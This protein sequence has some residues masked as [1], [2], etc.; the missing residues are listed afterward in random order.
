[1]LK[2]IEEKDL[3]GKGVVG[4]PDA[5]NLTARQ[6]QYKFEEIV[7]D[8]VIPTVNENSAKTATIEDINNLVLKGGSGDMYAAFYD[9]DGDGRVNSADDGIHG[10]EFVYDGETVFLNGHGENGKFK[11]G[12]DITADGIFVNGERYAV[13]CGGESEI[14]LSD[15]AVYMFCLD[16]GGKT[17]NFN[18][19]GRQT[20][21]KIVCSVTEPQ[22][23][24]PNTVWVQTDIL[25]TRYRICRQKPESTP[26]GL[27]WLKT[28]ENGVK[29][30]ILKKNTVLVNIAGAVLFSQGDEI[31]CS[32]SVF[33]GTEWQSTIA[34]LYENGTFSDGYDAEITKSEGG[35]NTLTKKS[36]CFTLYTKAYSGANFSTLNAALNKKIDVGAYSAI[37]IET[38]DFASG[39]YYKAVV[40]LTGLKEGVS[41][42]AYT[43]TFTEFAAYCDRATGGKAVLNVKELTGEYYLMFSLGRYNGTDASMTVRSIRLIP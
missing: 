4:L 30:D 5:P 27:L 32:V 13:N 37:E 26:D 10:Y 20:A 35:T 31:G 21:F 7:R 1:M 39:G 43:P 34:V 19:G 29:I 11:C 25:Y 16:V 40:G 2:I 33:D 22:N 24:Q 15:G 41:Y 9:S 28:S 8:V 17:V 6:M 14:T 18:G 42:T 23:P 38:S 3:S 36:D 12:A